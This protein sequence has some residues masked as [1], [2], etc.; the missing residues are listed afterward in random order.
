MSLVVII[1]GMTTLGHVTSD[2]MKRCKLPV[3]K[4]CALQDG[5]LRKFTRQNGSDS[6]LLYLKI[7]L[8]N[9]SK[10]AMTLSHVVII[11]SSTVVVV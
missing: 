1:V 6:R 3:T 11:I 5:M 8:T 9:E 10:M 7:S 4:F 2:G